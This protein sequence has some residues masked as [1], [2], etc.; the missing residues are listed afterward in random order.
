MPGTEKYGLLAG[1]L[2]VEK[3]LAHANLAE[4]GGARRR[5]EA[6]AARVIRRQR[7]GAGA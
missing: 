1:Q 7:L 6:G 3:L 2:A 5:F 4:H